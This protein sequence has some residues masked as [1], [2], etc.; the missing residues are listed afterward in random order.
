MG[1]TELVLRQDLPESLRSAA[2]GGMMKLVVYLSVYG[3]QDDTEIIIMKELTND[4]D[5][6][7][8]KCRDSN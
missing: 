3:Q 7:S 8:L 4:H 1:V 6:T 2:T 5:E